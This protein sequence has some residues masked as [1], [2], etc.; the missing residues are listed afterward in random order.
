MSVMTF[1]LPSVLRYTECRLPGKYVD[2]VA[3]DQDG[4]HAFDEEQPWVDLM[5]RE[6]RR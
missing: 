3:A 4:R 1:N 5:P 2:H 6:G